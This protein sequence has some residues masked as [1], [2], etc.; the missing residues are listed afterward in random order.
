M[1][2]QLPVIEELSDRRALHTAQLL[3]MA[4]DQ[5]PTGVVG[6]RP[7]DA[8]PDVVLNGGVPSSAKVA[9]VVAAALGAGYAITR[10]RR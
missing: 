6:G 5:G 7:E 4:L 8:Y 2:C 3:E 10:A 9:G 1:A